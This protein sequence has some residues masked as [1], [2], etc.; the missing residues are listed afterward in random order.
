MTATLEQGRVSAGSAGLMATLGIQAP[1]GQGT[2]VYL[3][4]DGRY[5]GRLEIEDGIKR[6]AGEGSPRSALWDCTR[7]C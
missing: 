5:L 7:P 6:D 1:Q 2:V 3:A 4:L